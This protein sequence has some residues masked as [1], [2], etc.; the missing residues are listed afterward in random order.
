MAPVIAETC[1][2]AWPMIYLSMQA[3][4]ATTLPCPSSWAATPVLA[5]HMFCC[6][7]ISHHPRSGELNNTPST[8]VDKSGLLP[9]PHVP[10]SAPQHGRVAKRQRKTTH[11]RSC[12]CG[13]Q[14]V[15]LRNRAGHLTRCL[16]QHQGGLRARAR[17]WSAYASGSL[18]TRMAARRSSA[19]TAPSPSR[20][21]DA[22]NFWPAP[23]PCFKQC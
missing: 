16:H 15:P 7:C 8:H 13:G 14:S 22:K 17:N 10:C 19:L 1:R 12:A 3:G 20:S 9:L 4:M 6:I 23:P 11:H 21:S 18:R 2:R 5:W